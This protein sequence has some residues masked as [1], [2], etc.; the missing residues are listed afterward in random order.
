[1]NFSVSSPGEI[2]VFGRKTDRKSPPNILNISQ[3]ECKLTGT[4]SASSSVRVGTLDLTSDLTIT[5]KNTVIH[6]L[7]VQNVLNLKVSIR[8]LNWMIHLELNMLD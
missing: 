4:I 1:M 5:L 2:C 6:H 8:H 3:L 7:G